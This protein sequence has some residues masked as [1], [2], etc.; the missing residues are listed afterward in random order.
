M[1]RP[2]RL[3]SCPPAALG[4]CLH[5]LPGQPESQAQPT[6][7][8]LITVQIELTL[9]WIPRGEMSKPIGGPALA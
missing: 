6:P 8:N 4:I 3:G 9:L 1:G 2:Q 7:Q 5:S